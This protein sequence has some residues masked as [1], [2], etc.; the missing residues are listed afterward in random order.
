MLKK[1]EEEAVDRI[2]KVRVRDKRKEERKEGK[3]ERNRHRE[4]QPE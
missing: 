2:A 3:R 1:R 4:Q